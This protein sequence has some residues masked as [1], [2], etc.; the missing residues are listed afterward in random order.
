MGFRIS[1]DKWEFYRIWN[2][3]HH[4]SPEFHKSDSVFAVIFNI[5]HHMTYQIIQLVTVYNIIVNF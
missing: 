1:K 3:F 2:H 5:H 4:F